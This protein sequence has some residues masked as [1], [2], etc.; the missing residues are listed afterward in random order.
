MDI[1]NN[2]YSIIMCGR[3]YKI[4][5]KH[6]VKFQ[7]GSTPGVGCQDSTLTIKT[8]LH[9]RHNHNLPTWVAFTELVKAF[10]TSNYALLIAI[11]VKYGASPRLCSE[12]KIMYNEIVVDIIIRKGWDIHWFKSGWQTRRHN[13]PGTIFVPNDGLRRNTIW[14]LYGPGIKQIP[15]WTQR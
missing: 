14:W 12:I 2:I 7:F 5:N 3:L 1:G 8:L 13:L 10:D 15:I 11:L 9:I 6:G 4:I